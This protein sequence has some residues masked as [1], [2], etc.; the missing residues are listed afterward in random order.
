VT[1]NH[2][3]PRLKH[4][5]MHY[6]PAEIVRESTMTFGQLRPGEPQ[7]SWAGI[8][9]GEPAPF[10]LTKGE[11]ERSVAFD[12]L[13]TV[14]LSAA[15]TQGQFGLFIMEQPAGPKIPT[16]RHADVHETFYVIEGAV[17]VY[18]E[19]QDGRQEKRRLEAG[20]FGYVPAGLIHTYEANGEYNKVLGVC[21][22]GFER[23]FQSLGKVTDDRVLPN[24]PFFPAQEHIVEAFRRYQNVPSFDYEWTV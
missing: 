13:T 15:E 20:D 24:P 23:F 21:T 7:P 5:I 10:F 3:H 1:G 4:A 8:L 12:S 19:H 2:E 22:A 17:T 18:L 6:Q 14:L 11:G 16:H 9:P